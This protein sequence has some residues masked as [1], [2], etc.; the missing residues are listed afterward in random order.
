MTYKLN[1][2]KHHSGQTLEIVQAQDT[3]LWVAPGGRQ[4]KNV[5]SAVAVMEK[6]AIKAG[7]KKNSMVGV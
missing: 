5:K 7:Y 1:H 4:Y 3:G 2:L 6:L